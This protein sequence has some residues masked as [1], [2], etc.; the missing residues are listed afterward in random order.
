MHRF[1]NIIHNLIETCGTAPR[2]RSPPAFCLQHAT[3]TV[4]VEYQSV[5]IDSVEG[6]ESE[7]CKIWSGTMSY[8]R[9][10]TLE[11]RSSW[12][13]LASAK[14]Y[15]SGN[16]LSMRASRRCSRRPCPFQFLNTFLFCSHALVPSVLDEF[17]PL[18]NNKSI[19]FTTDLWCHLLI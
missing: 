19:I 10:P 3:G 5:S 1:S 11:N 16:F 13:D 9:R 8:R 2:L 12:R 4:S 7:Y 6:S 17:S 14:R 18:W 15:S